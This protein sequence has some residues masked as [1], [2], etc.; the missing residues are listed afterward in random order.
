MNKFLS[1]AGWKEAAYSVLF[2]GIRF[3]NGHLAT[4]EAGI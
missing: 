2:A 4:R 1:A 3:H